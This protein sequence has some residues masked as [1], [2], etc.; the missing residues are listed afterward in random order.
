LK[1]NTPC[2]SGIR[3]A[4]I[5]DTSCHGLFQTAAV[6]TAQAP[7]LDDGRKRTRVHH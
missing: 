3:R 7:L 4:L 1:H 5:S 6:V 2:L